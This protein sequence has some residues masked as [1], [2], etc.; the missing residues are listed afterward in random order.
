MVSF[1]WFIFDWILAI[2]VFLPHGIGG[3]TVLT[4]CLSLILS[5][6]RNRRTGG[7]TLPPMNDLEWMT[8]SYH[9]HITLY[10]KQSVFYGGGQFLRGYLLHICSLSSFPCMQQISHDFGRYCTG[11]SPRSA[12]DDIGAWDTAYDVSLGPPVRCLRQNHK[13]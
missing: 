9:M 8:S 1:R 7:C 4:L 3:R 12:E 6:S 5:S 10:L 13:R 2:I 11:W